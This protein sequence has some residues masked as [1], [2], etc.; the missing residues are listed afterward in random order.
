MSRISSSLLQFVILY[1]N[2]IDERGDNMDELQQRQKIIS[3]LVEARLEQ[4]ISQAE[5][6]RKAVRRTPHWI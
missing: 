6:A 1:D 4:G 5:L 2:I 3:Q